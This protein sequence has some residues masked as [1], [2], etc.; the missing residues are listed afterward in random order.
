MEIEPRTNQRASRASMAV[1]YV[2]MVGLPLLSLPAMIRAGK[3]LPAPPAI[4]GDWRFDFAASDS[5]IGCPWPRVQSAR[6]EIT[7]TGEQAALVFKDASGATLNASLH[8]NG[9]EGSED[10]GRRT[11]RSDQPALGLTAIIRGQ[12]KDRV[13]EGKL[14][15]A[16]RAACG[17]LPFVASKQGSERLGAP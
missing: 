15:F 12:G 16:S 3:H 17:A 4:A 1:A 6:V 14:F 11:A 7:Q 13:V 9:L 5:S 10:I 8:G 2:L